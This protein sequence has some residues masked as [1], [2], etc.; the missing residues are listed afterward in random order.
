MKKT[1]NK[2]VRDRIVSVIKE[3]GRE[4]IF[5]TLDL[6][7]FETALFRKLIEEV[8]EFKAAPTAEE[9]ADILEVLDALRGVLSIPEEEIAKQKRKKQEELG[10][11]AS[12]I[13]LIESN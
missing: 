3:E 11:F 6:P 2:L 10:S 13:F 7:E 4:P 1:F 8:E 5:R 9:F 12:R